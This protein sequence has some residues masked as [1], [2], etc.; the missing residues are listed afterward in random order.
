[1]VDKMQVF[2]LVSPITNL[3]ILPLVPLIMA[4]GAITALFSLLFYPL[5]LFL[6]ALLN[7]IL[8]YFLKVISLFSS[9][10]WSQIYIPSILHWLIIPYYIFLL[11]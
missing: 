6:G 4:G 11:E 2:S 3:L 10:P 1:M 7:L 5:G 9:L 8:T